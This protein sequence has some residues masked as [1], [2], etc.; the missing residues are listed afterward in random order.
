MA[1]LCVLLKKQIKPTLAA[2][3]L[4]TLFSAMIY[5]CG[6]GGSGG[7]VIVT[8]PPGGLMA[9][10][11]VV[12]PAGF[13]LPLSQL[14][15]V[16]EAGQANVSA[17]G[18]FSAPVASAGPRIVQLVDKISG[19]TTLLGYVDAASS[20]SVFSAGHGDISVKGTADALLFMGLLG[21][22]LPTGSWSAFIQ[23]IRGSS[24]E[25]QVSSAVRASVIANPTAITDGD[26]G[27]SA[28]VGAVQS[29]FTGPNIARHDSTPAP[30]YTKARQGASV[31][32]V[33]VTGSATSGALIDVQPGSPQST[34]IIE[35]N[36]DGDGIVPVSTTRRRG[37]IFIYK[38]GVG[39]STMQI[40]PVNPPL[41]VFSDVEVEPTLEIQSVATGLLNGLQGK[42]AYLPAINP[43]ILLAA[44]PVQKVTVYDVVAISPGTTDTIPTV[45]ATVSDNTAL[46][47]EYIKEWRAALLQ[48]RLKVLFSDILEPLIIEMIAGKAEESLLPE[49]SAL[50]GVLAS[51]SHAAPGFDAA[52]AAGDLKGA[53]TA[54]LNAIE[55]NS[56]NLRSTYIAALSQKLVSTEKLDAATFQ[57]ALQ[58]ASR[59]I[60]IIGAIDKGIALV[61]ITQAFHDNRIENDAEIWKAT[62]L[63]PIVSIIPGQ[64]LVDTNDP[65]VHL[66]VA[67][68]DVTDLSAFRFKWSN[69]AL[70][71]NLESSTSTTP[72]S[73]GII[74]DSKCVYVTDFTKFSVGTKDTIT[75]Q[76]F[77]EDDL[78]NPIG[79]ASA[80]ITGAPSPCTNAIPPQVKFGTAPAGVQM[81]ETATRPG[82][83]VTVIVTAPADPTRQLLNVF[84]LDTTRQFQQPFENLISVDGVAAKSPTP[85]ITFETT[86]GLLSSQTYNVANIQAAQTH[87]LVFQM[88]N[89]TDSSGN[90]SAVCTEGDV[91][92]SAI[93][94]YVE[95]LSQDPGVSE[96]FTIQFLN[97]NP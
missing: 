67:I 59:A 84:W 69:T 28:A 15:V 80:T 61:D 72:L 57:A 21:G 96:S 39:P 76:V 63:Q 55:H 37:T 45:A 77:N 11:S 40:N 83:K 44:D 95:A 19:K 36:P 42:F 29:S 31:Q 97:E 10:G 62:V 6:G 70:E 93:P 92:G 30:V 81:S 43:P 89:P 85:N 20:G 78:D 22:M 49:D 5:G 3:L 65:L 90:L 71:G 4:A 56:N 88:L 75:V 46:Q 23:D 51:A 33:Y 54:V 17:N 87:T 41:D 27:I 60:A 91:N 8:P 82:D 2:L 1:S 64:S 50:E 32:R 9:K 24:Q 35:P 94:P 34:L 52:L 12:L 25:L 66:S 18:S 7:T 38:V 73:T 86:R 26:A 14:Q 74:P 68:R 58:D 79:T 47:A 53:A 13:K 48:V 16:T